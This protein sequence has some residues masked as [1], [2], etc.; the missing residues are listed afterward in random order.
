ME[1]R[2]ITY[3]QALNEAMRAEMRENADV[4]LLGE[5]IGVYGG[6]FKVTRDLIDE[7]GSERVID[8]PI[9]EAGFVGMG[10][11]AAMTGLRPVIE[12]MWVDFTLVAMDQ[13]LNQAAKLKYM[14]G[15]QARIPLVIRTQGGGGRGNGA[16][17]SQSLEGLFAQFP[18]IKVVCPAT[19][20]DAKGL[21]SS[22]IRDDAPVIFIEH[23]MLY[24]VKGEVP[25]TSYAIPFGKADIKRAGKDVTVVALSR[26]VHFALEAAKELEAEG[27]DVEV[28]DLRSLAPLD[29]DTVLMS[30]A[31]TNRLVIAHEASKSFNW[32]AEIAA[33]VAE[34][35][36][37][38]LDA[39][40]TRVAAEDVPV[41]YNLQLE[42]ETLPQTR[43]IVE[44][45]KKSVYA[46]L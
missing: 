7:F 5:D 8:T 40:I 32:G 38:E 21:L 36:F 23:K 42:K 43:D 37:D 18:G 39:P 12:I 6:V 27:I 3:A 29:M 14:S 11:G 34:E 25:E 20:Y 33:R 41:P 45:V 15:G 46:R 26:T 22:A 44:H 4:I 1:S 19:P 24:N 10:I 30:I 16:Q 13:I 17:H 31:K 28:I 2:I 35:A 9:S